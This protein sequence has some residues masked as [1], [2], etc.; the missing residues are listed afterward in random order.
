ML[1][2]Q[3]ALLLVCIEI[4]AAAVLGFIV[5]L[6]CMLALRLEVNSLQLL[7]SVALACVAVIVGVAYVATLD[8]YGGSDHGYLSIWLTAA[9]LPALQ[10]VVRLIWKRSAKERTRDR[11]GPPGA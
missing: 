3:F 10:N 4:F 9:S 11:T 5:G 6:S 8:K 1:P 7:L 2:W